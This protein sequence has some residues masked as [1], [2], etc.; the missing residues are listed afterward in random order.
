MN[1]L[2]KVKFL[3]LDEADRMTQDHCFPQLIQILQ[4]INQANPADENSEDEGRNSD[5][6]DNDSHRLLGLPG[7]RGEAQLEMLT[8]E[9][10]E[11]IELQ[12]QT[13]KVE[14]Q[15]VKD[16][17]YAKFANEE[18]DD[19]SMGFDEVIFREGY[20]TPHI[21]RQTFIY[22][23]TLTL[24]YTSTKSNSTA[25]LKSKRRRHR[26]NLGLD[27]GIAEI[28][29]K[30]NAMGDTKVVDLSSSALND[31]SK[32]SAPKSITGAPGIQLPA[33]L[34]LEQMKCTQRHKDSH[35]Y[36]YLMTTSQGSSGPCLVFCNSIAAVRRVGT[37]L[38]T[39][40]LPVRILHAHMQQ[41]GTRYGNLLR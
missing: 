22:S 26:H 25:S 5:K 19:D 15:E 37:T 28:L 27:G 40:G 6:D 10:L 2:S 13:T 39:L 23:A 1:D 11:Q 9:V 4:C 20:D 34:R 12:R 32:A 35:L 33:G 36:A 8:P 3:V 24:P 38:Q 30:C 7:I 16:E 14:P 31:G 41:V 18:E 17:D 21:H 29:E